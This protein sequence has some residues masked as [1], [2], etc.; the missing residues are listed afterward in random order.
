M[1]LNKSVVKISMNRVKEKIKLS[2][3]KIFVSRQD[4]I[5]IYSQNFLCLTRL[6]LL[7]L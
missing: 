4:Y 1:T 5:G 2:T 3:N 7:Y 6:N